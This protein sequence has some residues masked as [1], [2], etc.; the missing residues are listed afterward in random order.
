[1]CRLPRPRP[2]EAQGPVR[3]RPRS[4]AGGREPRDG[5]PRRPDESELWVLVERDEMPPTD[6]P[7]GALTHGAKGSHPGM[8]RRRRPGAF[9]R[10]LGIHLR[11]S[12]TGTNS[13]GDRT[14]AGSDAPLAGQVPPAAAPLPDRSCPRG[15]GRRGLVGLATKS[16]PVGIG[17]VL[18][19]AGS[20]A[21]I[22]TAGLG[23]LF[24]AAGNGVGSPQLLT[25]HRWL[26]TTAAVWLVITGRPRRTRC[27]PR[28]T[29]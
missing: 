27:P 2:G 22:P 5:D 14:P 28:G 16:D 9:S 6:S 15:R 26:G 10:C 18:L 13:L 19:M 3:I 7:H 1:M 25:A 20:S 17:S 21:A 11:R 12:R 24:A 8:D 4:P 29:K 23:W